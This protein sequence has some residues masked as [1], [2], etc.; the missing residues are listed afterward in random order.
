ML[1]LY[2]EESPFQEKLPVATLNK[3]IIQIKCQD[4]K[5]ITITLYYTTC[6]VLVQGNECQS[7][8]VTE[9]ENIKKIVN[10]SVDSK[11]GN[12]KTF[13]QKVR[14]LHPLKLPDFKTTISGNLDLENKETEILCE[15]F[16]S[17][18]DQSQTFVK[19]IEDTCNN[20]VE[21]QPENEIENEKVINRTEIH[22]NNTTE[23]KSKADNAAILQVLHALENKVAE[24]HMEYT[25][26]IDAL[27]EIID[28][29]KTKIETRETEDRTIKT[30]DK[31][32][33]SQK[34]RTDKMISKMHIDM[35]L[36]T[37]DV[38]HVTEN[39]Q[40]VNNSIK[41]LEKQL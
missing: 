18:L 36:N 16:Q 9:F 26:K 25:Q 6:R 19:Q 21:N 1:E 15:E 11:G 22:D 8:V 34:D 14:K 20:T 5:I 3:T 27:I 29:L 39:V 40:V 10:S 17:D 23:V 41:G 24:C 13:D 38:R 4:D 37:K 32:L 2:D 12:L 31:K 28:Q 35:D 7:W 30:L 33:Q